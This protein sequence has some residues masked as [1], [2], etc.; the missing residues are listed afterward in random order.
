M[1][2]SLTPR[3][4]LHQMTYWGASAG[5]ISFATT[6]LLDKGLGA[7]LVGLLLFRHNILHSAFSILHF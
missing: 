2:R 3:Y 6:F 5:I 4:L 1:K 7:A